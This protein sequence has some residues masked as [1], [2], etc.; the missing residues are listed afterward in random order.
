MGQA[1][2]SLNNADAGAGGLGVRLRRADLFAGHVVRGRRDQLGVVERGL[3]CRQVALGI[4]YGD[5]IGLGGRGNLLLGRG[6]AGLGG[7]QRLLRVLHRDD[8]ALV[9]L[10]KSVL[11]SGQAGLRIVEH[12]LRVLYGELVLVERCLHLVPAAVEGLQLVLIRLL[13]VG[14]CGL[15]SLEGRLGLIL[16]ALHAFLAEV[17]GRLRGGDIHLGRGERACGARLSGLQVLLCA[18]ERG[19]GRIDLSL[20]EGGLLRRG[21]GRDF[22]QVGLLLAQIGLRLVDRGL[23]VGG[24]KLGQHLTRDH[25]LTKAHRQLAQLAAVLEA[26]RYGGGIRDGPR[27]AD[28]HLERALFHRGGWIRG[29][30]L[31]AGEWIPGNRDIGPAH[32]HDGCQAEQ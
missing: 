28:C 22:G 12:L 2:L 25:L 30:L 15:V 26:Q 18:I 3:S 6:Q 10:V 17:Q 29:H 11:R 4:L 1:L 19:L 16:S 14:E 20:R 5:L 27:G 21:A 23:E 32:R 24:I 31:V 8:V 7:V 13:G 9:A